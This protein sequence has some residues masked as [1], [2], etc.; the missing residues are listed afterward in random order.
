M[1]NSSLSKKSPS[2][3]VVDDKVEN[4]RLLQNLLSSAGYKIRMAPSGELALK[5]IE[6]SLPDLILLDVKMPDIN[7][8]EVCL[9]LKSQDKTANIPVIFI[10]AFDEQIDK[11]KAFNVGGSDYICKPFE[12]QELLVKVKNQIT[13]CQQ[14][15]KIIELQK[16]IIALSGEVES[17]EF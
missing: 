10:S 14:K 15:Q 12:I 11:I 1:S 17:S 9:K 7:G 8:Y 5:T 2:I 16:Q 6:Y 3:L 13:I 4:L